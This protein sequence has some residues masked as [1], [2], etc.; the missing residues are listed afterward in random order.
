MPYCRDAQT[1]LGTKKFSS[2]IAPD[3]KGLAVAFDMR[4]GATS[5]QVCP[6]D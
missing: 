5:K 2:V 1:K 6:L 4:T 3:L